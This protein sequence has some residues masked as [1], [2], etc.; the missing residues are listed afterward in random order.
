MGMGCI[1][2]AAL[3]EEGREGLD[4]AVDVVRYFR[5][6]IR[7]YGFDYFAQVMSKHAEELFLR[8]GLC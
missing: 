5:D 1:I 3:L 2:K 4:E 7:V 6:K 8:R